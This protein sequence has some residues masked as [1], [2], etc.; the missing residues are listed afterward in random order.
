MDTTTHKTCN[1]CS[2]IPYG[3]LQIITYS[4][5]V[6]II[7][8]IIFTQFSKQHVK[9]NWDEYKC[10]VH[11][12]PFVGL[13]KDDVS[14][15]G[16]FKECIQEKVVPI[17]NAHTKAQMDRQVS[18]SIKANKEVQEKLKE[19]DKEITKAKSILQIKF[20]ELQQFF[21]HLLRISNYVTHKIQNFFLKIG[22]I[23]WT[24]YY[25]LISSINTVI[26]QIAR[27]NQM[28]S[29]MMAL[30][31]LMA[32]MTI[33]FPP[34]IPLGIIMLAVQIAIKVAEKA[35]QRRA[36][37]CFS[38]DSK[39]LL[40][41]Y[42]ETDISN[43][44]IGD[45]LFANNKVTGIIHTYNEKPIDVFKLDY[46][47]YVTADH[48]YMDNINTN[49]KW[50]FVS[51]NNFKSKTVNNLYCLVTSDNRIYTKNKIL[52][53]YE[54]VSAEDTQS[55]I[56]KIILSHLGNNKFKPKSEYEL[57]EKNNC[58]PPNTLIKMNNGS[59]KQIKDIQIGE[60]LSTG[61][62]IGTYKCDA[63][64]IKWFDYKNIII[65]PRIISTKNTQLYWDKIYNRKGATLNRS[66]H[67]IYAY[68]LI[69]TSNTIE[70][71]N[72]I[73]IRDFVET[74]NEST[75]DIISQF[76]IHYVNNKFDSNDEK[77]STHYIQQN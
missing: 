2:N 26:I 74:N 12:L 37:C 65:S 28:F 70:L 44:T 38:T 34:L 35:A 4:V 62:V 46:N 18:E 30:M 6:T 45:K 9:D 33:F 24:L 14:A 25:Y 55:F 50:K 63:R 22:A 57:G 54:E 29:V 39:I 53:D 48:I 51:E 20:E 71:D 27:F 68:H 56:S 73:F 5:I 61:I 43:I 60:H 77:S 49:W 47:A 36:Y 41:N 21:Q 19:N 10:K 16:N 67:T 52:L 59:F 69:T 58:L 64:N 3:I 40:N 75:Q 66:F 1:T 42:T 17:I 31:T 32:T 23:I 8:I 13:M 76:V 72:K 15:L 11:L 7:T